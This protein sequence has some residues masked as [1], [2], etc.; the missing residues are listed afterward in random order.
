MRAHQFQRRI[1]AAA[2]TLLVGFIV[3][4]APGHFLAADQQPAASPGLNQS[5]EAPITIPMELFANRPLVR[6]RINGQGPFAMLFAPE[7]PTTLIDRT[8]AAELNTKP[9]TDRTAS[10]PLEL[11]MEFGG[12]PL[13]VRV[14]PVDMASFLPE[15][16][17]AA[18]PRGIISG[19]VWADRLVTID[20][21]RYQVVVESGSLAEPNRRDVFSLK[22]EPPDVGITIVTAD[23]VV[24][25]RIDPLFPGGLLLPETYVKSIPLAS[26]LVATGSMVT[27]KGRVPVQEGQIA[28]DV[29][30]GMFEFS[31][32]FVQFAD[33]GGGCLIGGQWLIG[34]TITYDLANARVRLA[35]RGQR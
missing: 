21:P 11:G 9:Q 24:S 34:F 12:K 25:C 33:S 1:V 2:R 27:P 10:S 30:L 6:V 4:S 14:S 5:V 29:A 15:F 31:K 32:P 7:I 22:P 16:G 28:G 20:Y 17:P 3:T 35:R 26:K 19:S 18:R 13:N 23:L 8:L